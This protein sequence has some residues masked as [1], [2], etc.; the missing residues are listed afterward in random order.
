MPHFIGII[1]HFIIIVFGQIFSWQLFKNDNL[2]IGYLFGIVMMLIAYYSG[3]YTIKF[4]LYIDNLNKVKINKPNEDKPKKHNWF[5]KYFKKL[6]DNNCLEIDWDFEN[7][8]K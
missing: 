5:R 8:K 2:F 4:V 1:I 6:K 3:K 7:K